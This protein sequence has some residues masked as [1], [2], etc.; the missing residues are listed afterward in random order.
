VNVKLISITKP[1]IEGLKNAEDLVA[2]CARVSNPSNQMNSESAPKL[3]SFLIK[4]KHWSPFEMVDMTVE[5]KTSRAIAAQ[6][7][8]H[9][10]FSF[11]E[12]SQRYSVATGFED[13]EFR[14]QGDKNRQVGE[15]LL[16]PT[17]LRYADLYSSVKQ[18]IEASTIAYDKMIQGGIAKEV[19]R[20]ILPLTTE[21]T[22]Y[23]K[24][25]LRSWVHYLD[26]R[27]EQNTQKEHRLIADECKNIFIENFPIISEALQWKVE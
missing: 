10:S 15:N 21:T 6:I 12:F 2:Y 9:R 14:L 25:S 16:D 26:L 1:D 4:H 8:R 20:M 24:G 23:M 13:I 7:L 18:A 27:T 19:A 11:Q 5:I 22:M 3:L 17:D